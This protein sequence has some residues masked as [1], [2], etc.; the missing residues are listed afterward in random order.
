MLQLPPRWYLPWMELP[1][2]VRYVSESILVNQ[3]YSNHPFSEK[4]KTS[5]PGISQVKSLQI[6]GLHF[7]Q[8]QP[9]KTEKR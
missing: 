4:T 6:P 3:C 9:K 2:K 5:P 7:R 8:I 1:S